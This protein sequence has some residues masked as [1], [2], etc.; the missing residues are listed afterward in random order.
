MQSNPLPAGGWLGYIVKR[1]QRAQR[2][3][4]WGIAV[5]FFLGYLLSPF[6]R[7]I[8]C[9]QKS[10]H[11]RLLVHA[12]VCLIHALVW[13]NKGSI[14]LSLSVLNHRRTIIAP[15]VKTVSFLSPPTTT[16][17]TINPALITNANLTYIQ[18]YDTWAPKAAQY[19]SSQDV[20]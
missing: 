6:F 4:S 1:A 16:P 10:I 12:L 18:L 17:A 5:A 11:T 8:N 13:L 20:I 19:W 7:I 14:D 15:D 2:R 3:E 9:C